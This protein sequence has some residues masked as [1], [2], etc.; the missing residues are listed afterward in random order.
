MSKPSDKTILHFITGLESGGGAETFLA[1]ILPELE[2]GKHIVCSMRPPGKMG[3]KLKKTGVQ[4]ESLS[5]KYKYNLL[6][7]AIRYRKLIKRLQP[8]AQINYLIHAD[9]F[10]RVCGTLLGV[11]NVASFLRNKHQNLAFK[12]MEK[13]TIRLADCV[14][15]NSQPV[16]DYY[17]RTYTLPECTAVVPNGVPLPENSF[18]T[19]YL[20]ENGV[21]SKD[22]FVVTSVA[23][24][25]P[26]KSLGTLVKASAKLKENIPNL[27]VLIVG[28]GDKQDDLHKLVQSLG[29]EDTVKFLSKRDDVYNILSATDVFVLPSEKEGMSNALL[30][31]M[32]SGCGC[33]VS[34]IPENT[35]LIKD[36]KNGLSFKQG[37]PQALSKAIQKLYNESTLREQFGDRARKKVEAEYSLAST[38][39]Q[40][41]EFLNTQLT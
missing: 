12:I 14:L 29:V 10:G 30:E 5:M 6:S 11:P 27:T 9:T 37:N 24:L 31:A 15:A 25:H 22:D 3:D 1:R 32:A 23:R 33:V 4:V 18:K 7:A 21:L 36:D 40:L 13:L 19:D 39:Q 34:D 41:E 20:Y 28:D 35:E 16:M 26:Q 17:Q 8:D 38:S 2:T